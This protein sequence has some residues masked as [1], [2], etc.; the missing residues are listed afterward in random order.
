MAQELPDRVHVVV[1]NWL[2]MEAFGH[3]VTVDGLCRQRTGVSRFWM[4]IGVYDVP[5]SDFDSG[6]GRPG[7]TTRR[8][9]L[10]MRH[11]RTVA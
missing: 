9:K 10:T 4:A 11:W 6:W 8:E 3:E 7:I 5:H 2:E 1:S